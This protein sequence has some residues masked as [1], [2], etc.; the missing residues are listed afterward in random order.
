MT[1][2]LKPADFRVDEFDPQVEDV[3]PIRQEGTDVPKNK[4]KQ[5]EEA[6]HRSGVELEEVR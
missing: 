6:A 5:V 1:V 4:R 3:E 2:K